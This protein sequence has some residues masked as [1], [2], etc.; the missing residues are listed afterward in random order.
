MSKELEKCSLLKL[1][2]IQNSTKY[3]CNVYIVEMKLMID[4]ISSVP[5]NEL[6]GSFC[7]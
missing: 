1:L 5:R 3:N 4:I 7:R 2:Q 6:I